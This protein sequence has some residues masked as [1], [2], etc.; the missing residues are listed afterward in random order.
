MMLLEFFAKLEAANGTGVIAFSRSHPSSA[1][2]EG[3]VRTAAATW[4][5]L[6]P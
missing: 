3:W 2:R 1:M 6:H 4:R 5:L